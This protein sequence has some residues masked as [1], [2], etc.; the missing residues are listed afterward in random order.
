MTLKPGERRVLEVPIDPRLLATW[1]DGRWNMAAGTYSFSVGS[2]A[3]DLEAPVGTS[4]PAR[5]W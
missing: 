5:G 4:F 1:K 2:S 3:A